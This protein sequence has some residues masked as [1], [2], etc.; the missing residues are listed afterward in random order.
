VRIHPWHN[1]SSAWKSQRAAGVD[2][3]RDVKLTLQYVSCGI[4]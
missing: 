1:Q 2:I 4:Q 3:P